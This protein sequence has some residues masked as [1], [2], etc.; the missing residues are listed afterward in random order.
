MDKTGDNAGASMREELRKIGGE[1]LVKQ[2]DYG[3]AIEE[4]IVEEVN[5][6]LDRHITEAPQEFAQAVAMSSCEAMS[7]LL[8]GTVVA[9]FVAM[10]GK[11]NIDVPGMVTTTVK[12][13]VA[14]LQSHIE[15]IELQE[16]GN[17]ADMIKAAAEK[18]KGGA[19]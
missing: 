11:G 5:A 3:S 18:V 6:I 13:L 16:A 17:A 8:S 15:A 10:N 14:N 19:A 1:E 4:K 2:F 9:T 12:S 7:R